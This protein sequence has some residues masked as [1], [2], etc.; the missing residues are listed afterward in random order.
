MK[1]PHNDSIWPDDTRRAAVTLA[2]AAATSSDMQFQDMIDSITDALNSG[3]ALQFVIELIRLLPAGLG[4]QFNKPE[5]ASAFRQM[6]AEAQAY[7]DD[8]RARSEWRD[9]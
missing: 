3:R 8:M 9:E 1:P 7:E 4:E 2:L 5:T 6:A